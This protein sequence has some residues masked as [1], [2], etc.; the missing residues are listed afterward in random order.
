MSYIVIRLSL[1]CPPFSFYKYY[2]F[3]GQ[4][5][6][7]SWA[8]NPKYGPMEAQYYGPAQIGHDVKGAK[9]EVS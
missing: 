5:A 9:L 4:G 3:A 1:H 7:T 6:K 8:H 2:G